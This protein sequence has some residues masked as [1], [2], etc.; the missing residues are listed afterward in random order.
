MTISKSNIKY[1][2][3]HGAQ[4]VA[5]SSVWNFHS[6]STYTQLLKNKNSSMHKDVKYLFH[7]NKLKNGLT[8]MRGA[9]G[10]SQHSKTDIDLFNGEAG[11]LGSYFSTSKLEEIFGKK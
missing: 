1:A 4:H 11:E 7:S 8:I 9:I 5:T 2:A 6:T 3:R 10:W